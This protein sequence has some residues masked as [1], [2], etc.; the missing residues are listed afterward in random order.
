MVLHNPAVRWGIGLSGGL[1]VA[2]VAFFFL[3]GTVQLVAYGI[4]L[5]DIFVTPQILKKAAEQQ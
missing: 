3:S 1:A 4:A 5:L 2:A